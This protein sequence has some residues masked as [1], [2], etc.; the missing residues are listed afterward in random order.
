[1]QWVE[2]VTTF[3]SPQVCVPRIA[4]RMMSEIKRESSRWIHEELRLAGFTWQEGYGAFTFAAPDLEAVR[5][6]VLN[7]EEHHLVKMFQEEYVAMLK[8]GMVEHDE[9]FFGEMAKGTRTLLA[10]FQGA[11]EGHGGSGDS[12]SLR[13]LHHRLISL[14]P[15][16]PY[17][18]RISMLIRQNAAVT[19][20]LYRLGLANEMLVDGR[21][22][23]KVR[24]EDIHGF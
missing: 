9:R 10:P 22:M 14:V 1:M 21:N 3:T 6:Y 19:S 13:S 7:Q 23:T 18:L 5:A 4:W 15:P 20:G 8:R 2:L 16:G 12:R 11:T 17:C 24:K